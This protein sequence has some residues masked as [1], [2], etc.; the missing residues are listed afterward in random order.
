MTTRVSLELA[1]RADARPNALASVMQMNVG[2]TMEKS[3]KGS[4]KGTASEPVG[5]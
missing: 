3:A 2:R 5:I 4:Q 1:A